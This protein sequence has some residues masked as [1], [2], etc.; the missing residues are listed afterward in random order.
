[1]VH[2]SSPGQNLGSHKTV[3]VIIV[4][5]VVVVVV[6][7]RT[8]LTWSCLCVC[9]RNMENYKESAWSSMSE[10]EQQLKQLELI[11]AQQFG[12]VDSADDDEE[13]NIDVAERKC[14]DDV[15]ADEDDSFILDDSLYCIACKKAFKSDKA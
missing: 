5:V 12:E 13:N 14:D 3:V 11:V 8:A 15:P 1:M 6:V 2:P 7:V 9:D 10:L 4:V